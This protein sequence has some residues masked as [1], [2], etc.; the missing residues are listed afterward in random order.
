MIAV[1][2]TVVLFATAAATAVFGTVV[3][4]IAY[5]GYRKHG[6]LTMRYLALGIA[7]ITI[8]P[9]VVSY[10]FTPLLSLPD[11]VALLAILLANILGLLAILYSLEV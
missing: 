4:S 6:S 1:D 5:Q 8:S 3:A 10:G 2:P 7:L 11:P 9:F